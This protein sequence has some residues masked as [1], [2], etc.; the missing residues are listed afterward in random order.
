[1]REKTTKRRLFGIPLLCLVLLASACSKN[2][3]PGNN[4]VTP[5]ENDPTTA[6]TV[7]PASETT[8]SPVP[9]GEATPTSSPSPTITPTNSP[10]PTIT[11]NPKD[12]ITP[13]PAVEYGSLEQIRR[14]RELHELIRP[15]ARSGELGTGA[16]LSDSDKTDIA[17]G[18]MRIAPV[19]VNAINLA[20]GMKLDWQSNWYLKP[21]MIQ[22][23]RVAGLTDQT[24]SDRINQRI[25][26]VV[27]AMSDPNFI[28][29]DAGIIALFQKRGKPEICVETRTSVSNGFLSVSVYG[30]YFWQETRTFGSDDEYY[31]YLDAL[32]IDDSI[33]YWNRTVDGGPPIKEEFKYYVDEDVELL[34]NLANGEEV[35]LSDLF[36]EGFDYKTYINDAIAQERYEYWMRG[37]SDQHG[38]YDDYDPDR[39]YDGAGVFSGI[40]A[41]DPFIYYGDSQ[42]IFVGNVCYTGLPARVADP[43]RDIKAFTR[44]VNYQFL[45]LQEI[46]L[47][48]EVYGSYYRGKHFGDVKV[49]ADGAAQSVAVFT[50]GEGSY[51]RISYE[52]GLRVKSA[53]AEK[54]ALPDIDFL[55]FVKD[56]AEQEWPKAK[57]RILD[58]ENDA[59]FVL[60]AVSINNMVCYPNG[61]S[62]VTMSLSDDVGESELDYFWKTVCVWMK[63]GKF[64]PQ[65]EL[66]DVSYEELLEELFA[67]LMTE[68]GKTALT[69]EEAKDAA[70]LLSGYIAYPRPPYLYPETT[71][72][73]TAFAFTVEMPTYRAWGEFPEELDQKLPRALLNSIYRDLERHKDL[74]MS[75]PYVY[76][77][78]LRIYEGYS[79]DQ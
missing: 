49:S 78:H 73:W 48:V 16:P 74:Q 79:F 36:P 7:T 77:K 30:Y 64:V 72:D 63:D 41:D 13:I 10:S 12:S 37:R 55:A 54:I 46:Q 42:Q 39:E 68:D 19:S 2:G 21:G 15:K 23:V 18:I 65:E 75:D 50:G 20:T 24:V 56:W 40:D 71:W 53:G 6:A 58:A 51:Y 60:R 69:A 76:V 45:P 70:K 9:T 52:Y 38:V 57:E 26:E 67:G 25:D 34:F 11:P 32:S 47:G 27:T 28:P 35:A 29:E 17:Y 8:P 62:F 3:E 43:C 33:S 22:S 31:G 66:L 44:Q 61:Y 59:D 5:S 1:M 14:N 4:A